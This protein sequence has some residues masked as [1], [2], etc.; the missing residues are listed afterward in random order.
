[1]G[2]LGEPLATGSS[3]VGAHH[4][5]ARIHSR[6]GLLGEPLLGLWGRS[7][8][9]QGIIERR[10]IVRAGVGAHGRGE[11]SFV[12]EKRLQPSSRGL[13]ESP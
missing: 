1:M 11:E 4:D 6:R 10:G 5:L 8:L 13:V 9:L 7:P 3:R 2:S 12:G